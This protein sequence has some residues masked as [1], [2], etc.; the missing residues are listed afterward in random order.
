MCVGKV[1][2]AISQLCASQAAKNVLVN[3]STEPVGE[4]WVG[5]KAN[6]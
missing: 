1:G 6:G 4:H 2:N 5:E 3:S